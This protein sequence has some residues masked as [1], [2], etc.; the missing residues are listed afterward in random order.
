[1][2]QKINRIPYKIYSMYHMLCMH[3]AIQYTTLN[4]TLCG[5]QFYKSDIQMLHSGA[6]YDFV[7]IQHI[8]K[9]KTSYCNSSSSTSS[10]I[11]VSTLY[12]SII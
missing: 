7:D 5:K 9:K 1:M 8:I 6:L 12:G 11:Q 4:N 2:H 10:S 3:R